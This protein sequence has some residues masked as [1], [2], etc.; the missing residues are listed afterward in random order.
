VAIEEQKRHFRLV[1]PFFLFSCQGDIRRPYLLCLYFLPRGNVAVER[2]DVF[3]RC[4]GRDRTLLEVT[5]LRE[6]GHRFPCF[7]IKGI[8]TLA[9]NLVLRDG[10]VVLMEALVGPPAR[11]GE[12]VGVCPWMFGLIILQPSQRRFVDVSTGYI[13]RNRETVGVLCGN[14]LKLA[15][16]FQQVLF[17][18]VLRIAVLFTLLGR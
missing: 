8:L 12:N 5:K 10:L 18:H 14:P 7:S 2:L 11:E 9:H 3:D 13:F 16:H 6:D 15:D 17:R 4:G 1:E